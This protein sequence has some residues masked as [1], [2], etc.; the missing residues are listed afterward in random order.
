[1]FGGR[2]WDGPIHA[3]VDAVYEAPWTEYAFDRAAWKITPN[4]FLET[5][6]ATKSRSGAAG[7][8]DDAR[9][10]EFIVG[11]WGIHGIR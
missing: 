7:P 3:T 2:R 9:R 10:G 5:E 4:E 6:L 1:M 11:L 8:H